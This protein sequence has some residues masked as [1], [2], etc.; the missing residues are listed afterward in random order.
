M[1][2][3]D[4]NF[5]AKHRWKIGNEQNNIQNLIIL[6]NDKDQ[7]HKNNLKGDII[8][9]MSDSEEGKYDDD[10]EILSNQMNEII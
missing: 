4:I 9:H 2:K 8:I 1:E 5:K 6:K 10:Q 3:K 7:G